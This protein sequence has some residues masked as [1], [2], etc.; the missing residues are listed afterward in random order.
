MAGGLPVATGRA[1]GVA[2]ERASGG[3]GLR[4]SALALLGAGRLD[5]PA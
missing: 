1:L 3:T 4:L 2:W 5:R